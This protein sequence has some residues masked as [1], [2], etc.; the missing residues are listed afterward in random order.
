MGWTSA[1][2][3]YSIRNISLADH[4]TRTRYWPF[5]LLPFSYIKCSFATHILPFAIAIRC[6]HLTFPC[7]I[8]PLP[9]AF[10]IAIATWTFGLLP[11]ATSSPWFA[12]H[13]LPC[14][15]LLPLPLPS[16]VAVAVCRCRCRLLL[17]FAIAV[18]VAVFPSRCRSPLP[19]LFAVTVRH[20]HFFDFLLLFY[21]I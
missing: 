15:C 18:A 21:H 14:H 10:A 1:T 5:G 13:I 17:P 7:A 16:A 2:F 20:C 4:L 3:Y 19:L 6:C 12:T 9:F 11:F 8:F